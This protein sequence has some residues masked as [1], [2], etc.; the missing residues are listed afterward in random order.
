MVKWKIHKDR[1]GEMKGYGPIMDIGL[2][3]KLDKSDNEEVWRNYID[4]LEKHN[5]E[6]NRV[7]GIHQKG[8]LYF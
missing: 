4:L 8:I 1:P 5:Y 2:L 7:R 3:M 6:D